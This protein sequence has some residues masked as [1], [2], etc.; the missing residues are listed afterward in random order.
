MTGLAPL[1]PR[2]IG[3]R[4]GLA[5][6]TVTNIAYQVYRAMRVHSRPAL[7]SVML[8]LE[9]APVGGAR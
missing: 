8:A 6:V 1:T 4:L 7:R 5:P 2:E 9:L 3:A